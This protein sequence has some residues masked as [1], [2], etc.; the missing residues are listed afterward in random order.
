MRKLFTI[1]LL[2]IQFSGF[3]QFGFMS[4]DSLVSTAPKL[5]F[6]NINEAAG[7][8]LTSDA[9][10]N[11]SWQNLPNSGLWQQNGNYISNTNPAGF[12]SPYAN[13]LPIDADNTSY[14]PQSPANGNGTRMAWIPGRS[15]F[16]GG[17]FNLADG[18]TRFISESIGLFSF[19]Y[20]LNSESR[21]RGGVAIGEGAIAD[22]TS[23]TIAFGENVQVRGLK[24]IGLGFGNEIQDGSSNT[25]AIGEGNTNTGGEYVNAMGWGL[26]TS[27]YGTSFFGAFNRAI[28]EE[29]G[30][31][32]QVRSASST[33]SL[34]SWVSTD[35]LFVIG[36]GPSEFIR[37]NALVIQKNGVMNLG[38]NPDVPTLFKLRVG[39]GI[40][41]TAT[42]QGQGLK[43]TNLAGTGERKVCTDPSGNLIP[44]TNT[45]VTQFH[46][47]SAMGF[48]PHVT[49]FQ[50]A[51]SFERDIEKCLVSFA[52]G[53]KNTVAYLYAPVE[54][55]QGFEVSKIYFNY[56]QT[57]QSNMT[58]KFLAVAKQA[59]S[60]ASTL[61]TII[62]VSGAGIQE[63]VGTPGSSV[64]INNESIYYFLRVESS[65]NWT[66]GSVMG[67]RGV[68]FTN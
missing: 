58:L 3:A 66:G 68:V 10:G 47:V 19:C 39:G 54:L 46:N 42:I 38:I 26:R 17:T 29:V 55:P 16:Q 65:A 41:S 20:G 34:D 64:I 61:A 5:R 30:T 8:V 22:G 51:S 6:I 44:C 9:V 7:R 53:T 28:G 11:A 25:I 49:D 32:F 21:S 23:N 40:S 50:F 2:V 31:D 48:Q 43:A 60:A 1:L 37:S 36:N 15:A 59:N 33:N 63:K 27:G 35:P 62:T 67:L 52:S 4:P 24:N 12:W 45:T 57:G 13:A 18:S 56:L 14:P